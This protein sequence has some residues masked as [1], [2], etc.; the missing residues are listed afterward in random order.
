[1]QA[2]VHLY[3]IINTLGQTKQAFFKNTLKYLKQ[4][5]SSVQNFGQ[6]FVFLPRRFLK[7]TLKI[8]ILHVVFKIIMVKNAFIAFIETP[9]FTNAWPQ[10]LLKKTWIF[11][12]SW[13]VQ[14]R[15]VSL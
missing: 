12:S 4:F 5:Y 2:I 3:H 6:L 13:Q 11:K 14:D 7:D 8:V 9:V 10:S 15:S 1:M